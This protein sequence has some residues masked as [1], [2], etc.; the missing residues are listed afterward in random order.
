M[1][2]E[3]QNA[4][5]RLCCLYC[6]DSV[7]GVTVHSQYCHWNVLVC[8]IGTLYAPACVWAV[9]AC[10][11]VKVYENRTETSAVFFYFQLLFCRGKQLFYQSVVVYGFDNCNCNRVEKR[12]EKSS[13]AVGPIFGGIDLFY[14]SMQS[15]REYGAGW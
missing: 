9:G 7:C 8:R 13:V 4:E 6:I 5:G 14:Y 15:S 12:T 11:F 3:Y 10:L 2:Q 1:C